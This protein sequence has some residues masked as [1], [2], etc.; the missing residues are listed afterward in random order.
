[1]KRHELQR[2]DEIL[3]LWIS[4]NEK[5]KSIHG[6]INS[7]PTVGGKWL[8]FKGDFPQLS[9]FKPDALSGKAEKM[10]K[11]YI[12]DEEKRAF[13]IVSAFPDKLRRILTEY[14]LRKGSNNALTNRL[15]T[16]NDVAGLLG[17]RVGRY[18]SIRGYLLQLVL[19][20][21]RMDSIELSANTLAAMLEA[22]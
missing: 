14:S 19:F 11:I 8:E 13:I 3:G 5:Q 7:G 2:I 12:S 16:H 10:R 9:G 15:W 1:M 21:D 22:V 6:I 17:L 4:Y 20:V 18:N